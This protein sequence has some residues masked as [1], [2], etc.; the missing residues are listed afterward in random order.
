MKYAI[1]GKHYVIEVRNGFAEGIKVSQTELK[2]QKHV[3]AHL[4]TSEFFSHIK[5]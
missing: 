1:I 5:F 2:S 3:L 4:S